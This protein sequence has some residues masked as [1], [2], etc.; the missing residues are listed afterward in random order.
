MANNSLITLKIIWFHIKKDGKPS[1]AIAVFLLAII[2]AFVWIDHRITSSVIAEVRLAGKVESV[3]TRPIYPAAGA[4]R[5]YS[6]IYGVRLDGDG[7]I[8]FA[9]ESRRHPIQIGEKVS[10]IRSRRENGS[11]T[12]RFADNSVSD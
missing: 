1:I 5:G 2:G 4:G 6:Y 10:V 7:S 12:Y 9:T 8:V 3:Q 11:S